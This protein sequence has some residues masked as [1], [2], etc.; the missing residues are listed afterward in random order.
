MSPAGISAHSPLGTKSKNN[1]IHIQIACR[2]ADGLRNAPGALLAEERTILKTGERE[3]EVRSWFSVRRRVFSRQLLVTR[4]HLISS[5]LVTILC[6]PK[7][8][9]ELCSQSYFGIL[10]QNHSKTPREPYNHCRGHSRA[11]YTN[12]ASGTARKK[13]TRPP[14]KSLHGGDSRHQQPTGRKHSVEGEGGRIRNES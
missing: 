3:S 8:R 2:E 1:N 4:L 5:S 11:P 10:P 6:R 13:E 14:T 9:F 12:F 7:N